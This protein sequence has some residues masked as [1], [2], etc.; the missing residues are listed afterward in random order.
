MVAW[1]NTRGYLNKL[2]STWTGP[3]RVVSAAGSQ[4]VYGVEDIDTG[5]RKEV[6]IARMSPRTDESLVV[7]EGAFGGLGN[8]KTQG[9]FQ[10]EA[11]QAVAI[12]VDKGTEW[13]AQAGL[14]ESEMALKIVANF[15]QHAPAY[16]ASQWRMLKLTKA[17]GSALQQNMARIFIRRVVSWTTFSDGIGG[18]SR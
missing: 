1:A 3:S 5:E 2:V 14:D 18:G 9:E 8:A 12:S 7:M 10:M 16:L 6:H 15:Y 4:Q 11:I 13:V 17:I